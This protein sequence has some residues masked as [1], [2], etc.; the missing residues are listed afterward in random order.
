[1]TPLVE[2]TLLVI[3]YL[4]NWTVFLGFFTGLFFSGAIADFFEFIY[5]SYQKYRRF[6]RL[7]RYKKSLAERVSTSDVPLV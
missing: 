1:M 7:K 5:D 3:D 4:V 2:E 6:K